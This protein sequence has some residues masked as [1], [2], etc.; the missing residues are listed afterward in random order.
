ME[1]QRRLEQTEGCEYKDLFYFIY[2]KIAH[3]F[4]QNRLN[5][6][7]SKN[8]FCLWATFSKSKMLKKKKKT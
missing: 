6:D 1:L 7:Y 2:S 5:V 8:W 4:L 3:K